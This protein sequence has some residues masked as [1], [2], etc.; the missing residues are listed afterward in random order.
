MYGM[1]SLAPLWD[2][3]SELNFHGLGEDPIS[4]SYSTCVNR[5]FSGL[6]L[7]I[8]RTKINVFSGRTKNCSPGNVY[9]PSP[10]LKRMKTYIHMKTCKEMFF[11]ALIQKPETSK[12]VAV[13]DKNIM[14][15]A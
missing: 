15:H 11:I 2:G 9:L 14:M 5:N 7:H 10:V 1:C 12:R 3:F 6:E 8:M 13:D 4:I